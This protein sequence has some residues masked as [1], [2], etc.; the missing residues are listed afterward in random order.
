MDIIN[1]LIASSK[2]LMKANKINEYQQILNAIEELTKLQ[3]R[4][5]DLENINRDLIN[6]L[7]IREDLVVKNDAYWSKDGQGPFCL[8]CHGAKDLL[9]RMVS[10]GAG[11]HK[12]N[13]CDNVVK[14]DPV[15]YQNKIREQEDEMEGLRHLNSYQ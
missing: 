2:I 12:C 1:G 5:S 15:E 8:T 13:N 3:K 11:Q 14:T 6:K 4:I 9:V 7:K 10:W